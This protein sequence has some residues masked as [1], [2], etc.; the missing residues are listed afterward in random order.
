MKLSLQEVRVGIHFIVKRAVLL[1]VILFAYKG[2]KAQDISKIED[3]LVALCQKVDYWGE[4]E[5]TNE[6]EDSL[7]YA[8]VALLTYLKDVCLKYP[9]TIKADFKKLNNAGISITSSDDEKIRI[10]DWDTRTGGT[11]RFYNALGQYEDNGKVYVGIINDVSIRD[12]EGHSDNGS[13]YSKYYS[14]HTK[15]NKTIYLATSTSVESSAM[16]YRGIYACTVEN[17]N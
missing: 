1:V 7:V 5:Y 12:S 10:Y 8:N 4:H 9:A 14:I 13:Y 2:S 6:K 15:D 16:G 3:S 11:M 17:G